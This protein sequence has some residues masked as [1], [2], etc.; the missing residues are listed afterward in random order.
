M[1]LTE[2]LDFYRK[3]TEDALAHA[4]SSENEQYYPS[5][6]KA[7][8]YSALSGGKRLRPALTMEFC[9]V[10]GGTLE[11][12]VPF[13]AAL[14]MVHTYSL[15]HDDLPCMDDDDLRRGRPTNHKVFG[16]A[17][18]VLAGDALL[19]RAFE[20]VLDPENTG[21]LPAE[22]VLRAARCLAE[23][24]GMDGMIGGQI[25]DIESEGRQISQETLMLRQ[26]MKTGCLI[27]AAAVMGCILAGR[28]DPETL[29]AA[30]C[31]ADNLGLAFQIEDDL[32][33]IEGDITK[34]GKPIGSDAENGKVTFPALLGTARCHELVRELTDN[35]IAALRDFPAHA[36]LDDLANYL[37]SR[38]Y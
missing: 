14:E 29:G 12:A 21:N 30:E 36:F 37:V 6:F 26:R 4:L 25:M 32:L 28:S 18:A 2:R 24:S 22:T 27:K 13:A 7:A 8:R 15:I 10:C 5:I 3:L 33:D 9:R 17:T 11:Q 35:A 31:Y 38:D 1:T 20:T 34:F 16:E 23:A 19:N